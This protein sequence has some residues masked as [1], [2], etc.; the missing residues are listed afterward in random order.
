MSYDWIFEQLGGKRRKL[1]LASH[2]APHGRPRQGP[3]VSD[4]IELRESEV[5]YAGDSPP[6]R[7]IFGLAFPPWELKGRFSDSK[8]GAGFALAKV[9]EVKEFV[10]EAQT[11]RITWGPTTGGIGLIKRFK[12]D[13]EARYDV[14]WEMTILID[15]DD[16]IITNLPLPEPRAPSEFMASVEALLKGPLQTLLEAPPTMK[17]SIFDSLSSLVASVNGISASLVGIAD[18][19]DSFANAP[20]DALRRF[21]AGLGQFRTALIK[22]RNTY[23]NFNA[24]LAIE[25][26][27]AG[28]QLQFWQSQSNFSRSVVQVLREV[29]AA[30]RE[31]TLA[32]RGSIQGVIT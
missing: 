23:E 15:S 7:H 13:R 29:A 17:G 20:L 19:I 5:Y 6:T 1:T 14:A 32:E 9:Q 26:Q 4:G 31:A 25:S 30:Q 18:Q 2:A 8:G 28:E 10:A 12:P 24:Q 22:L 3:V 27:N 11:V 16:Y 21:N